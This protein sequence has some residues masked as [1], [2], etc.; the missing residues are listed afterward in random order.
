MFDMRVPY[1]RRYPVL[2]KPSLKIRGSGQHFG[3]PNVKVRT[4]PVA[5]SR[6][7]HDEH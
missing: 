5:A 4:A 1:E 2:I 3:D 6:V 7:A